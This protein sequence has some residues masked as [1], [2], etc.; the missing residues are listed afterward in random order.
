M[1]Q[2]GATALHAAAESG[3]SGVVVALLQRG[4]NTEAA[5]RVRAAAGPGASQR[6]LASHFLLFPL[7]I[8]ARRLPQAARTPLHLAAACGHVKSVRAL[9]A[10]G[11]SAGARTPEGF[12][13]L[14]VAAA[15]GAAPAVAALLQTHADAHADTTHVRLCPSARARCAHRRFFCA[16]RPDRIH[17]F[18][19]ARACRMGARRCTLPPLRRATRP[20]APPSRRCATAAR[21]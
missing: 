17:S 14:H 19:R 5:N 7:I 18:T 6:A 15:A 9:L 21:R 16:H 13:P 2:S 11:A 4:A 8:P 10:G 12:T 3:H 20:R 1:H